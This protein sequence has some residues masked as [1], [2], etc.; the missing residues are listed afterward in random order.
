[1]ASLYPDPESFGAGPVYLTSRE[2]G[3]PG[4]TPAKPDACP[5]KLARAKTGSQ[6]R[7]RRARAKELCPSGL[8]ARS[9]VGAE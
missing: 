4:L 8:P 7:R 2:T 1:M 5:S 9:S 6:P 3:E